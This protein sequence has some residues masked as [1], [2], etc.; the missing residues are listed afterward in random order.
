[1]KAFKYILLAFALITPVVLPAVQAQDKPKGEGKGMR[2]DRLKMMQEELA[3]TEDQVAKIKPIVAAEGKA[4]AAL[5]DD[6]SIAQEDKRGKMREIR[7]AH[8]SQIR[9]VLTPEQ[10]AKFDSMGPGAG[11]KGKGKGKDKSQP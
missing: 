6:T 5:R 9:A 7:Q 1:M 3:L 2:G 11:G 10:Q 8:A 4:M